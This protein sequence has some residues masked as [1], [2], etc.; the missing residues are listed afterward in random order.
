MERRCVH[1][2]HGPVEYEFTRK[3]VKNFN[4]RMRPDG[5]LAVSAPLGTP[6]RQADDFVCRKADW[7][8]SARRQLQ[9]RRIQ[10][11]ATHAALLGKSVPLCVEQGKRPR[12]L[13]A[14]GA[15]RL[16]CTAEAPAGALLDAWRFHRAREVLALAMERAAARFAGLPLPPVRSLRIR[17]MK[18]RW[19]SCVPAKGQVTL[20]AHLMKKPFGCIE[21]VAAH[22]LCHL[23]A[24]NHGP[25]FYRLLGRVMPD[26]RARRARLNQPDAGI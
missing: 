21:Y 16:I 2:S 23:L 20:N 22:E 15:V 11:P 24:P 19:G 17:A 8:A 10:G 9:N 1:T 3:R 26:H 12:I 18:S 14:E 4:M 5:T 7:V 13:A 6:L 25:D